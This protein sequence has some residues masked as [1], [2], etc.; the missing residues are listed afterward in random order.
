VLDEQHNT[1][2]TAIPIS[3]S[4]SVVTEGYSCK[5]SVLPLVTLFCAW[6]RSCVGWFS[7]SPRRRV[8]P[9]EWLHNRQP[10]TRNYPVFNGDWCAKRSVSKANRGPTAFLR[11]QRETVSESSDASHL[12]VE[13][14][15]KGL[16]VPTWWD[17]VPH[18][19]DNCFITRVLWWAHC[20]AWTLATAISRPHPARL[21]SVRI[22]QTKRFIRITQE[23]WRNWNTIP[24]RLLP[25]PTHRHFAKSHETCLRE[26]GRHFQHLLE[27]CSAK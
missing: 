10:P 26:G 7:F 19:K 5:N 18:S 3:S 11:R 13:N 23:A 16:L 17:D 9:L 8:V 25:I 21:L 6:R 20:W 24:N 22:S 15:R 27:S 4:A 2:I 12:S 1:E 14:K